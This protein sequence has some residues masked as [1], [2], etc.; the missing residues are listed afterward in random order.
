MCTSV[1]IYIYIYNIKKLYNILYIKYGYIFRDMKM[2]VCL[3]VC[4]SVY[5]DG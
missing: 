5:L 4:L 2:S 1:Y 3:S